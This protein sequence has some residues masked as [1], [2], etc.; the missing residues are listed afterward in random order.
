MTRKS[1]W[2]RAADI[3]RK[4]ER[5]FYWTLLRLLSLRRWCSLPR[6]A[7]DNVF[8][9]VLVWC[10]FVP[11]SRA[12]LR[13]EVPSACSRQLS[14]IFAAEILGE[15]SA[16]YVRFAYWDTCCTRWGFLCA[17][18]G[19]SLI[20]YPQQRQ[21]SHFLPFAA[22][23]AVCALCFSERSRHLEFSSSAW[24]VFS[25]RTCRRTRETTPFIPSADDNVQQIPVAVAAS[26]SVVDNGTE[27]GLG[28]Y[29]DIGLYDTMRISR[30]LLGAWS[31]RDRYFSAR[32]KAARR[33]TEG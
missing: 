3:V 1:A 12:P 26:N 17:A 9:C 6:R 7:C 29:L 18:I 19:Y 30:Q 24:T 31:F 22:L 33:I 14:A 27:L 28:G 5:S 20:R 23:L 4:K 13:I 25:I 32:R 16:Y 2:S 10:F 8:I 11:A 15:L 21:P